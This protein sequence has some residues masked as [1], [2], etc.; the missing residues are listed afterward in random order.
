[1]ISFFGVPVF[2]DGNVIDLGVFQLQVAEACSGLRYLFPLMSFGFLFAVLYKGPAWHKAI[3]FLSALPIT[4][5]M[6][7]FR[8]GVIGVLVDRYGIE[9]AEGFLHT[10]EGWIIFVACIAI[11]YLEAVLLQ[12]LVRNPSSI[13]GMLD[14]D[15][16]LLWQRLGRIRDLPPRADWS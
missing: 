11:L 14:V 7:S 10:F 15:P 16:K 1:M 12:R 3:L 9:Q 5:L 8:I 2:L 6:N 4:V 13:H